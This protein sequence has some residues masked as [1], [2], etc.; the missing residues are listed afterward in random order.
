ML[1]WVL[2]L[3]ARAKIAAVFASSP[4]S[5]TYRVPDN[6]ILFSKEEPNGSGRSLAALPYS[7]TEQQLSDLLRCMAR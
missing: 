5:L 3:E 1:F 2:P 6:T 7:T 4:H